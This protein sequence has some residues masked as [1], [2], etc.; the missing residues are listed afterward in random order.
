MSCF[1]MQWDFA[2][3]GNTEMSSWK[4][5]NLWLN[6]RQAHLISNSYLSKTTE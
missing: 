6:S 5:D 1:T 3:K 4:D 2:L